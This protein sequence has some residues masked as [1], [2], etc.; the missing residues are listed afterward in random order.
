MS[1]FS[2]VICEP[3]VSSSS[4]ALCRRMGTKDSDPSTSVLDLG[5]EDLPE[6]SPAFDAGGASASDG[7]D[8][9]ADSEGRAEQLL[10]WE[11]C[12]A[13]ALLARRRRCADRL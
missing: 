5:E 4:R 9:N 12:W 1:L 7:S 11:V 13:R 2:C 10:Y 6:F 8:S 3:V